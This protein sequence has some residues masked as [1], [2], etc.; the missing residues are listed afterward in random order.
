MTRIGPAFS[1]IEAQ[2]DI[3]GR[4]EEWMALAIIAQPFNPAMTAHALIHAKIPEADPADVLGESGQAA[5]QNFFLSPET[6]AEMLG[7]VVEQLD[8]LNTVASPSS[9]T[10]KGHFATSTRDVTNGWFAPFKPP[11]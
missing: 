7:E 4:K 1:D 10:G 6:A 2:L 8:A 3:G 11:S 5:E 9:A